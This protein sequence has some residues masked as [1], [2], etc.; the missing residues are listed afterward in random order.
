MT[1]SSHAAHRA[2]ATRGSAPLSFGVLYP[3]DDIVAVIDD[4]AAAQQ[5][6]RALID[7]GIPA[8]DIDVLEGRYFWALSRAIRGRAGLLSH[9]AHLLSRVFSDDAQNEDLFLDEAR[10][11]HAIVMAH[12]PDSAAAER[13][14][15]V[16]GGFQAHDVRYY[17]RA[18]VEELA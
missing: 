10:Q 1:L 8:E 11:G 16:L 14:A 6:A 3:K 5:A 13:I 4:Y 7:A 18:C 2:G 12:A 17:R 9:L 15:A